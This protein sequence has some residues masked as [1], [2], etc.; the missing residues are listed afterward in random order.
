MNPE[1]NLE[2]FEKRLEHRAQR[3]TVSRHLRR[4]RQLLR[5]GKA[6]LFFGFVLLLVVVVALAVLPLLR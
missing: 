6:A 2:A 4:R 5:R 3:R 1:E